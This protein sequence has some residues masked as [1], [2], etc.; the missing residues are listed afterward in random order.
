[1]MQKTISKKLEF[2]LVAFNG[3][4]NCNKVSVNAF[5]ESYIIRK[6][7]IIASKL[8]AYRTGNPVNKKKLKEEIDYLKEA[9]EN[10]IA[11]VTFIEKLLEYENIT[12]SLIREAELLTSGIN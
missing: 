12:D 7:Q 9:K 3:S 10:K 11:A 6:Q 8:V 1:M 2:S 4:R 5:Y